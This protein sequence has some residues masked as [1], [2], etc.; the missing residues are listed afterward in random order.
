MRSKQKRKLKSVV[1]VALAVIILLIAFIVAV[2][3]LQGKKNADDNQVYSAKE[4][5]KSYMIVTSAREAMANLENRRGNSGTLTEQVYKN[6]GKKIAYLTFD[7]GPSTT[8]TPKILDTLERENVNA[9]FF[10]IG[11]NI[12]LSNE[13]QELVRRMFYDGDSIG[14]HTY[15]HNPNEL[16]PNNKTN[17]ETFISQIDATNFALKSV[18]G[19]EFNTR[20]LRIPGG[21]ITRI[22]TRDANL[23]QLEQIFNQRGLVDIDW[24]CYDY[25][26][27]GKPKVAEQLIQNV[28]KTSYGK[29]KLVILM[30]DTYGKEETAKALPSIIDYL[31]VQGYQFGTLK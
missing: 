18:L 27:E 31:K 17:I 2:S 7:D 24:N 21:R 23:N 13:S 25:D 1:I 6:D 11:S 29:N 28:K 26:A 9:T 3:K 4:F 20:I 8:N 10:L 15:D 22:H 30:H 14:N 16:F 12:Q 19:Q 5:Q